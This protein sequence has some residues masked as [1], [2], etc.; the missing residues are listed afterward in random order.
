MRISEYHGGIGMIVIHMKSALYAFQHK[1]KMTFGFP[2]NGEYGL[3]AVLHDLPDLREIVP[4]LVGQGLQAKNELF[5]Y[6]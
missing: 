3:A 4:N 6:G 1:I 2:C 5:E